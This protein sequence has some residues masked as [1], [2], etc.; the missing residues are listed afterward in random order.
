MP[1]LRQQL[2]LKRQSLS[3]MQ[4]QSASVALANRLHADLS[5][6]NAKRIAFYQPADGEIDPTIFLDWCF[7]SGKEV[8]LPIVPEGLVPNRS[9]LLFQAYFPGRSTLA[10]NRFG[11]LEPRFNHRQCIRATDLNL[12]FVPL[13]GFDRRGN[14]LGMG[15]GYYDRTFA[16]G[17]NTYHQP[18]LVGLAHSIQ[19][20]ELSPNAW[21]IPLDCVFTEKEKIV[22]G[23]NQ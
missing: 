12:V 15:K 20:L 10:A 17:Q 1:S 6:V 13:V 4:Q 23:T 8:Y 19:E 7:N 22:S 9:T 21:D 16:S 3:K 5:I 18:R 11:I 14:R 2:R